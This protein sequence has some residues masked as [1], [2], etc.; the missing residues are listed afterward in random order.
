MPHDRTSLHLM[1]LYNSLQKYKIPR[2][3]EAFYLHIYKRITKKEAKYSFLPA[4]PDIK[5]TCSVSFLCQDWQYFPSLDSFQAHPRADLTS[6]HIEFCEH[7]PARANATD[8]LTM[9][10]DVSVELDPTTD[11]SFD[12]V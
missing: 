12:N 1:L 3:S 5:R 10:P 4:K 7:N 11:I 8:T 9:Q 2:T 6:C